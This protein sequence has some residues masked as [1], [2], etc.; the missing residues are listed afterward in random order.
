[1]PLDLTHVV[2]FAAGFVSGVV[3]LGALLR[4][5]AQPRFGPNEV[6]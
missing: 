4:S 1:M 5:I 3:V 2:I 6:S